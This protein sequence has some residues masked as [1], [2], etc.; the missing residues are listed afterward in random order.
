M[1]KTPHA[2]TVNEW[3]REHLAT[4]ALG[5]ATDAYNQ[6]VT[7]LPALIKRLESGAPGAPAAAKPAKPAKARVDAKVAAQPV[8]D[9]PAA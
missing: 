2:E 6:V 4:G 8:A 7:A 9:K 5:R 1:S 3:F